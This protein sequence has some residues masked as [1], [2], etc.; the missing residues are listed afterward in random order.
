MGTFAVIDNAFLSVVMHQQAKIDGFRAS[1]MHST[2]A[3]I[4]AS[5]EA[6]APGV[7]VI[8]AVAGA[9]LG[10]LGAIADR[11]IGLTLSEHRVCDRGV[12]LRPRR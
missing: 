12:R 5:L 10:S 4:N 11:D 8:L 9:F 2:R 3:Y 7:A 1:G 6:T